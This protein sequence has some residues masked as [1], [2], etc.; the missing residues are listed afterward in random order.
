VRARTRDVVDNNKS[1]ISAQW[2]L[3]AAAAANLSLAN[4][5]QLL[6]LLPLANTKSAEALSGQPRK[7][8]A[9]T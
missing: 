4:L 6:L 8:W 2:Q 9:V 3:V 5:F 7:R 1:E